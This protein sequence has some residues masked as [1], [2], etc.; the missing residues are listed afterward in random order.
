MFDGFSREAAGAPG[1]DLEDPGSHE[2]S[3]GAEMP[4]KPSI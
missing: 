1:L 4:L 3:P 2:C